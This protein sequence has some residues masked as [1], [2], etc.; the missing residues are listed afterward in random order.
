M[1]WTIVYTSCCNE[2][3]IDVYTFSICGLQLGRWLT[4]AMLP[5]H[6]RIQRQRGTYE[7]E[8]SRM[9]LK[10]KQIKTAFVFMI[11]KVNL[12]SLNNSLCL[13]MGLTLDFSFSIWCSTSSMSSVFSR[14]SYL[15]LRV[16]FIRFK[17]ITDIPYAW[18]TVQNYHYNQT[19]LSEWAHMAR[20]STHTGS[21]LTANPSQCGTWQQSNEGKQT[22]TANHIVPGLPGHV[23]F[24]SGK[25]IKMVEPIIV[26]RFIGE[27]AA[28][29]LW[30]YHCL[31]SLWCIY[32]LTVPPCDSTT[33]S[34]GYE[35]LV[36][37]IIFNRRI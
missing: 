16:P 35:E 5:T 18:K 33:L 29:I 9:I 6:N 21:C 7:I 3:L 20:A 34:L 19:S 24:G 32:S 28:T 27:F 1:I 36:L 22:H 15:T 26:L 2:Q 13:L 4:K 11:T 8:K 14:R 10:E 30:R 37:I 12:L 17:G 25:K 23:I 31:I